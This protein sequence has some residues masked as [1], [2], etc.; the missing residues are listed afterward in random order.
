MRVGFVVDKF[1]SL[2]ETFILDQVNGFLERGFEVGV[3]CNENALKQDGTRNWQALS[4]NTV[5]WWGGLAPL[6]RSLRRLPA[7]V[8]D[9]ISTAFDILFSQKLQNFDVIIAH[10]GNNG[11]RVA[12]V[13]K[14]KKL[15]A[16]LVTIFHGRDVGRPVRDN[17][18][19]QY[20]VL[21][22]QGTLQ[23]TVNDYFRNALLGAGAAPESVAVH[24]M[25]VRTSEVEYS[26]RSWD[27]GTLNFISVCR[28]TEKKG[29][30]FALRAL[31]QLSNSNPRLDWAYTVIGGGELLAD[32]KQLAKSL[33]IAD[34]V[35]FLGARPHSEVKQRLREAHVFL[36]PSVTA[37]DG[38]VEGIPVSLMEA[39]A[40][41][42]TVVSTYHSGIPELIEDQKTGFL[43]P[44][45]DVEALARKLLWIAE[46]PTECEHIAL[47]AR[48]KIEADFNADVLNDEFAHI[49]T[50]LAEAKLKA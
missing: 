37:H 35:I 20:N 46:N 36:L 33:D 42:L 22:D 41:G 21:F 19:W 31:G 14:R 8:W 44:E 48:R 50:R 11:L 15:A 49:I 30:E 43:V 40:A 6:R 28:L 17:S 13:L 45:R 16:P 38:D 27:Q 34:R 5:C 32:L 10:F 47:A 39:M 9:K 18:L 25:G 3:I 4:D 29:I 23:L 2:S 7:I 24:H 12:R 1:P 26:W